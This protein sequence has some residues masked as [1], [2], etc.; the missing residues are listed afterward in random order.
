MYARN[1]PWLVEIKLFYSILFCGRLNT[2]LGRKFILISEE[3]K[4]ALLWI[5]TVAS[6]ALVT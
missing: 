5:R 6:Y 2:A 4:G 1:G 3:N